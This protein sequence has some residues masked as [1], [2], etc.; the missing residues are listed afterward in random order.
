MFLTKKE[1]KKNMK[2]IANDMVNVETE[3]SATDYLVTDLREDVDN[4]TEIISMMSDNLLYLAE[5]QLPK[6]RKTKKK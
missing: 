5:Q 6:K 4:L 3:L 1:F 2:E